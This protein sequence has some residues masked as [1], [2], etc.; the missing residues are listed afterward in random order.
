MHVALAAA[1]LLLV[2]GAAAHEMHPYF[3]APDRL[4]ASY[5]ARY[6]SSTLQQ[7]DFP[8]GSGSPELHAAL[9]AAVRQQTRLRAR[10]AAG[11]DGVQVLLYGCFFRCGGLGDRVLG[12]GMTLKISI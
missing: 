10:L 9:T 4:H 11:D 7:P 8:P 1:L 12:I 3:C 5:A 2:V 6:A